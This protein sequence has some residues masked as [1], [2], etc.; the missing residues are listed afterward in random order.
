MELKAKIGAITGAAKEE[1]AAEAE[2]ESAGPMVRPQND[3]IRDDLHF[4]CICK[5]GV[6]GRVRPHPGCQPHNAPVSFRA[7]IPPLCPMSILRT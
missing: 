5:C 2:T 6:R 1:E 4:A 3:N 7:V